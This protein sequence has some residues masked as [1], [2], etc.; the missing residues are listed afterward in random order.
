MAPERI[1]GDLAVDAAATKAEDV[2]AFGVLCWQIF[3]QSPKPYCK[4]GSNASAI[5]RSDVQ[6]E[7]DVGWLGQR[8]ALDKSYPVEM[9]QLVKNCLITESTLRPSMVDIVGHLTFLGDT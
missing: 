3:S 5:P 2:W 7:A 4:V 8:L 9:R 6:I 1:R